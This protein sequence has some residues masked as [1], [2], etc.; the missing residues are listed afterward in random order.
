MT[1]LDFMIKPELRLVG[2]RCL[3]LML[4]AMLWA[5]SARAQ[6]DSVSQAA[7]QQSSEDTPTNR[8][9]SQSAKKTDEE[10]APTTILPHSEKSRFWISG[11]TNTILQWHPPFRARYT[12]ENSLKLRAE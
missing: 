12:G 2:V 5:S 11:Q 7:Q 4:A 9:D 3:I 1:L 6:A 8:K 10:E